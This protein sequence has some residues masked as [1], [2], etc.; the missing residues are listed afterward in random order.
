MIKSLSNCRLPEIEVN[1]L[2]NALHFASAPTNINYKL[3]NLC[4]FMTSSLK[5]RIIN[6]THP[7]KFHYSN[8]QSS[9]CKFEKHRM[10][11]KLL[12]NHRA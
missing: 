7:E 9:V 1:L 12:G 6:V 11:Q 2:N 4:N 5:C 8:Y 3:C 10:L